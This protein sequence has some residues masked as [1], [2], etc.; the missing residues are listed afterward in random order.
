MILNMKQNKFL[1]F[2]AILINVSCVNKAKNE[3]VSDNEQIYNNIITN[4]YNDQNLLVKQTTVNTENPYGVLVERKAQTNYFYDCK[5]KLKKEV[6]IIQVEE[7]SSNSDSSVIF[8]NY[9][10][11][12]EL[13]RKVHIDYNDDT[14]EIEKNSYFSEGN[15][16]N[17]KKTT[18]KKSFM[19]NSIYDTTTYLIKEEYDD[20]LKNVI[21]YY[22]LKRKKK[23]L[24]ETEFLSYNKSGNLERSYTLDPNNDTVNSFFVEFYNG[25]IRS[26]KFVLNKLNYTTK[27]LYDA[28][29]CI[30]KVITIDKSKNISDT[31]YYECDDLC[32]VL[33]IKW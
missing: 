6:R 3:D 33:K 2:L 12:D 25:K 24:Q 15:V 16:K 19:S 17:I 7:N 28:N 31:V 8:Y 32:N 9:N 13:T 29:G 26:K 20:S 27:E 1:L 18:I 4:Y 14:L 23:Q 21:F 22:Q 10:Q 11:D 30:E 5:G